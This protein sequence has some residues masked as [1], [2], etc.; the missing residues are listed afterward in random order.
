MTAQELGEKLKAARQDKDLS[1]EQVSRV[2]SL[3]PALVNDLEKGCYRNI[4]AS[5]YV[6]N[7]LRKYAKFLG[8]SHEEIEMDLHQLNMGLDAKSQGFYETS[9]VKHEAEEKKRSNHFKYYLMFVVLVIVVFAYLYQTG[10][11]PSPFKGISVDSKEEVYLPNERL[12]SLELEHNLQRNKIADRKDVSFEELLIDSMAQHQETMLDELHQTAFVEYDNDDHA[13]NTE[14]N[15]HLVTLDRE[16]EVISHSSELLKKNSRYLTSNQSDVL[17]TSLRYYAPLLSSRTLP[18]INIGSM[19]I[20]AKL[21]TVKSHFHYW[22]K[23]P[24]DIHLGVKTPEL[25]QDLFSAKTKNLLSIYDRESGFYPFI[26]NAVLGFQL[27][28][29]EK[30]LQDIT[31]QI[32]SIEILKE[33]SLTDDFSE[34]IVENTVS[35]E[36][37]EMLN[38]EL[39]Q[40][41]ILQKATLEQE[42]QQYLA[43]K[44]EKAL[45][46][47]VAEDITT[48]EIQDHQGRIITNRVMKRGDEYQME[49]QGSYDVYLGNPAVIDKITVNGTMIPEYYY[50]PLTEEAVSIR[51]SLNSEQYR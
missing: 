48:L 29:R 6:K 12:P 50:K 42:I 10:V 44:R 51:F 4:G 26:E 17:G 37:K 11:I 36:S 3:R 15:I 33:S 24:S 8:I 19:P 1:I 28:S 32:A 41:L 43:L 27:K 22:Y 38:S 45:L 47:I 39:Q 5:L 30:Q 49:G 2:L 21:S 31:A 40:Y 13:L 35:T 46:K 16:D 9:K 34:A 20:S 18:T 7:Y 25:F 23:T 14:E